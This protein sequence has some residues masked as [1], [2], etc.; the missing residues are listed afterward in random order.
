[1]RS[2]WR[3]GARACWEEAEGTGSI[4][5][6]VARLYLEMDGTFGGHVEPLMLHSTHRHFTMKKFLKCTPLI[7]PK[8]FL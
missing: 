6:L 2:L 3:M 5:W 7:K 1:M 4:S 8:Y